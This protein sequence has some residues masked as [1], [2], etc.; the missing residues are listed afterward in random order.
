MAFAID[1]LPERPCPHYP[2][3]FSK[4]SFHTEKRASGTFRPLSSFRP[5][6][7][8]SVVLDLCQRVTRAGKSHDYRDVIER[9][10][11]ECRKVIVFL[12]LLRHTIGLKNSRHFFIQPEVKPKPIITRSH[13]FSR[14]L[15]Q[16][17]LI[18]S[19]FDWFTVLSVICDWLE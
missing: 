14:A 6:T 13:A 2:E 4:R 17:H 10:S 16:L 11:F 3:E 5:P 1:Q 18:T 7:E 9:F 12:Q 15:C 19:S 8:T